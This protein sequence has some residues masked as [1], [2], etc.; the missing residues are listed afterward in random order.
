M[1]FSAFS[2][3]RKQNF[4][5]V[6]IQDLLFETDSSYHYYRAG[7]ERGGASAAAA[8]ASVGRSLSLSY[9]DALLQLSA[10]RQAHSDHGHFGKTQRHLLNSDW[11]REKLIKTKI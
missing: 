4:S 9:G 7:E 1:Y 5:G 11:R 6:K 3:V 2:S 8:T 10:A